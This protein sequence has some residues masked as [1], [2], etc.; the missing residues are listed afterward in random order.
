[1]VGLAVLDVNAPALTLSEFSDGSSFGHTLALIAACDPLEIVLP[2]TDSPLAVALRAAHPASR[3]KSLPRRLFDAPS[4]LLALRELALPTD[5][6]AVDVAAASKLLALS[7]AAALV[8]H[9]DGQGRPSVLLPRQSLAVRVRAPD[10]HMVLDAATANALELDRLYGRMNRTKT[11]IGSRLLKAAVYMPLRNLDEIKQ[12]QAAVQEIVVRSDLHLS[13]GTLLRRVPDLG[14]AQYASAHH[15]HTNIADG[16]NL[17]PLATREAELT[18]TISRLL[19]LQRMLAIIRP[20]RDLLDTTQS[21]KLKHLR[22]ALAH[23]TI[24]DLANNIQSVLDDP[25][26]GALAGG[27]K[28]GKRT[29]GHQVSIVFAVR[30]GLA[31]LLDISRQQYTDITEEILSLGENYRVD[32][33]IPALRLLFHVRRGY[34]LQLTTGTKRTTPTSED[35]ADDAAYPG[36]GPVD[37]GSTTPASENHSS[38]ATDM[39]ASTVLDPT[40]FLQQTV[41]AKGRRGNAQGR[42]IT[43]TTA[44]LLSLNDRLQD[45]LSEI[46]LLSAQLVS[47]ITALVHESLPVL[48]AVLEAFAN[49]DLL[50]SLA[51]LAITTDAYIMPEFAPEPDAP[52]AILHGRHPL[53]RGS[54]IPNSTYMSSSQSV[55]VIVGANMAGKSTYMKQVGLLV[56]MAHMG[57]C[58]PCA[59][60]SVRIFDRIFLRSGSDDDI[61]ASASTFAVEMREVSHMV[62][63]AT[64]QSLVLIDE[65]GRGTSHADGQRI[66]YAVMDHL[67]KTGVLACLV[68]HYAALRKLGEKYKEVKVLALESTQE[69]GR[70]RHTYAVVEQARAANVIQNYG[71]QMA[72]QRGWP[73]S[74]VAE[75]LRIK[76]EVLVSRSVENATND[77]APDVSDLIDLDEIQAAL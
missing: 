36:D 47:P 2:A 66:A 72:A 61:A 62:R 29:L 22:E 55:H 31:P 32:Y 33:N 18:A 42:R 64:P 37:A 16:K 45:T 77:V 71:I 23:P 49:L 69:V 6:P 56:I 13:L 68:T 1:M 25:N 59:F 73:E 53:L 60:A 20:M 17:V 54:V 76:Q 28:V 58:I 50:F 67:V 52:L 41:D 51:D 39:S 3:L 43:C 30:S 19:E 14:L 21:A 15:A 48:H 10:A 40:V 38:V 26:N 12:R 4:G 5:R 57:S 11:A 27:S 46:V 65:L 9:A 7:C 35:M 70:V 44:E 8:R 75:A 63:T 34:Y 24:Q 74:V